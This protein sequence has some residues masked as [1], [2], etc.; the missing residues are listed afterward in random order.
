[1]LRVY[2][3][4]VSL[5]SKG[6]V[7]VTRIWQIPWKFNFSLRVTDCKLAWCQFTGPPG[8]EPRW[9]TISVINESTS[10]QKFSL[11]SNAHESASRH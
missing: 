11:Q 1:M 5:M 10:C 4:Q 9:N 8:V 6:C 3:Y 2:V 7:T